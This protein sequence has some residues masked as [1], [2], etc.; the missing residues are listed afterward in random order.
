MVATATLDARVN[1][2]ERAFYRWR[3]NELRQ[4]RAEHPEWAEVAALEAMYEL[5]WPQP[6]PHGFIWLCFLAGRLYQK[7]LFRL[8]FR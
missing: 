1:D 8:G 2:G 7:C 3:A 5:P 4:W 6:R